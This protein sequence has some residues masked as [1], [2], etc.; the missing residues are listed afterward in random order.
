M[1]ALRVQ[2][3]ARIQKKELRGAQ[4]ELARYQDAFR[5]HGLELSAPY[6]QLER[7]QGLEAAEAETKFGF[8]AP[9]PNAEVVVKVEVEVKVEEE[10]KEENPKEKQNQKTKRP[11]PERRTE[12]R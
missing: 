11:N 7:E 10:A 12:T 1:V 3:E 6:A 2:T 4:I 9:E 5:A 8:V